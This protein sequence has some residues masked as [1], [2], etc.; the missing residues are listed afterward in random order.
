M[1]PWSVISVAALW[2]SDLQAP[3]LSWSLMRIVVEGNLSLTGSYG[4]VN[5]S[6]GKSLSQ[7]GHEV[8]FVGLDIHPCEISQLI[9]AQGLAGPKVSVGGPT[10]ART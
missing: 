1:S 2:L 7:L 10:H 4:I 3:S 9:D 5:F 6:L 8:A